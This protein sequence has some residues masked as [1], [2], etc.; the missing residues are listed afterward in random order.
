MNGSKRRHSVSTETSS[1]RTLKKELLRRS[2]KALLDECKKYKLSTSGDKIAIID[3]LLQYL[4]NE[5]EPLKLRPMNQ[6]NKS[7][8]KRAASYGAPRLLNPLSAP[9]SVPSIL[10]A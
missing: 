4:M 9:P 1:L 6:P 10:R 3:R 2:H 8:R 7:Y 5:P